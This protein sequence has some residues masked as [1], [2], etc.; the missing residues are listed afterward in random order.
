MSDM[1]P[2]S[3]GKKEEQ[4]FLGREIAQH[5][6]YSEDTAIKIDEEVKAMVMAANDTAEKVLS[7]NKQALHDMAHALLEKETIVQDDIENI[8]AAAKGE[9]PPKRDKPT[10]KAEPVAEA[11]NEPETGEPVAA[12][13]DEPQ[14]GEPAADAA[15]EPETDKP[16]PKE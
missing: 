14:T 13:V 16:Q 15:E 2:L 4:I 5:R 3:F 12:A 1:G 10:K 7:D 11:V 6:D 9:P 8:I